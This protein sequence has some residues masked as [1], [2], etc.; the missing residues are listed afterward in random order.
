MIEVIKSVRE[1]I[2]I[3]ILGVVRAP[4][5]PIFYANSIEV[6]FNKKRLPSTVPSG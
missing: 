4:T 2:W 1:T 5:R 3:K 6:N